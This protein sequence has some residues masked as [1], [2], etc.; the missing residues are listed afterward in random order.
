MV[1]YG[2]LDRPMPGSM[3]TFSRTDTKTGGQQL[4]HPSPPLIAVP[5]TQIGLLIEHSLSQIGIQQVQHPVMTE[6]VVRIS[7]RRHTGEKATPSDK[8]AHMVLQIGTQQPQQRGPPEGASPAG[9]V[10]FVSE[11]MSQVAQW[12]LVP[13]MK[14]MAAKTTGTEIFIV[15]VESYWNNEC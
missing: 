4:Q 5:S 12:A 7:G 11:Q 15:S 13:E 2:S 14:E 3:S 10:G 1:V 9:Q 6:D 8:S